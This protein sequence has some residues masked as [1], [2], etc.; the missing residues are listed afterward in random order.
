MPHRSARARRVARGR[1]GERVPTER[2]E[3]A[4][5]GAGARRRPP[6]GP[7][8]PPSWSRRRRRGWWARRAARGETRIFPAEGRRWPSRRHRT[9]VA[10]MSA[11]RDLQSQ[12]AQKQSRK[13]TYGAPPIKVLRAGGGEHPQNNVIEPLRLTRQ[14]KISPNTCASISC[15][16]VTQLESRLLCATRGGARAHAG[17]HQAGRG[18]SPVLSLPRAAL[19]PTQC[20]KVNAVSRKRS[21]E[22]LW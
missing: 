6:A 21:F 14:A 8:R 18:L 13:T 17:R 9:R 11:S 22:V 1:G 20:A 4:S 5:R 16:A 3:R 15:V 2:S 19:C 10:A 7:P 12:T